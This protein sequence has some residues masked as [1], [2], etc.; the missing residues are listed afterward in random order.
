MN[1]EMYELLLRS[2]DD[3]LSSKERKVLQEA[4]TQ[5]EE[6]RAEKVRIEQLRRQLAEAGRA[7]FKPFFAERVVNRI[8][9]LEE[10][11]QQ[12]FFEALSYFFKRVVVLGAVLVI[13]MLSAQFLAPSQQPEYEINDRQTT[14]DDAMYHTYAASLEELL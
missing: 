3:E 11:V 9:G 2:F 5:S 14:L 6:L 1:R 10:R 7:S 4:L 13:L 12:D 8:R